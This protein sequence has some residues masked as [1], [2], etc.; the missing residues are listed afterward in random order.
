MFQKKTENFFQKGTP[1]GN[2]STYP[3]MIN[4]TV[5]SA[6]CGSDEISAF[7]VTCFK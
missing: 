5:M 1:N 2:Q 3:E 7:Y 4:S 6:L